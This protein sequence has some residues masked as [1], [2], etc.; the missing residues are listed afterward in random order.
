MMLAGQRPKSVCISSARGPLNL[1]K[2][3]F[4]LPAMP[5]VELLRSPLSTRQ[6]PTLIAPVPHFRTLLATVFSERGLRA[7]Q[8]GSHAGFR[9]VPQP[10]HCR[11]EAVA[12]AVMLALPSN[13]RN[14]SCSMPL[15]DVAKRL[16]F[17]VRDTIIS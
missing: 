12:G 11:A 10:C 9:A 1:P 14:C 13:F 2:I 6:A 8:I 4:D 5:P 7:K 15:P 16:L 17:R 3:G